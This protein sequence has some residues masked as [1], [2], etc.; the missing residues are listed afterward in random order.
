VAYEEHP[1][2]PE[3]HIA[4]VMRPGYQLG[5]R[6]VRPAQVSVAREAAGRDQHTASTW[7]RHKGRRAYGNGGVEPSDF[8]QP[9][10][11]ER[12]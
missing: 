1:T 3:G 7:P 10:N 12:A 2:Q 6:V 11:I 4:A 5:E 9:R 8:H